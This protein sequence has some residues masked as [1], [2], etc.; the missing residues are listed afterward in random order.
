MNKGKC[1][2]LDGKSHSH[3]YFPWKEGT[4]KEHNSQNSGSGYNYGYYDDLNRANYRGGGKDGV[5]DGVS[6]S[7]RGYEFIAVGK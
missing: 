6:Y 2:K 4:G 1:S 3:F 5:G 7:Y